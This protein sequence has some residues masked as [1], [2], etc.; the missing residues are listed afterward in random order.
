MSET[1]QDRVR[2]VVWWAGVLLV[3]AAAFA[4]D[5]AAPAQQKAEEK[6]VEEK[7]A[8]PKPAEKEREAKLAA[9]QA[10]D[11]AAAVRAAAVAQQQNVWPD[12][13]FER[14]VF[15]NDSNAGGARRRC[16]TLLTLQLDEI[17]RTCQLA[18]SQKQ[19]LRLLGHGD[20]KRIFDAFEAAKHHFNLLANDMN[21]FQEIQPEIMP[22]QQAIQQGPFG[23]DSLLMKSLRHVLTPE[24]AAKYDAVAKERRAFRHRARVELAIGML[25]QSMSFREGQRRGLIELL[26]KETKPTRSAT[27]YYDYYLVLY[28]LGRMEDKVK[29]MFTAAEWRIMSRHLNQYR[30]IVP[31]LRANGMIAEDDDAADVQDAPPE[32]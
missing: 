4:I 3:A 2:T 16:E 5:V 8:A 21:H 17:D 26:I 27:G 31:N 22:V 10:K 7:K 20:I 28:N 12:D 15:Q 24:Q 32:R 11:R 18:E 1:R 13:Q 19:K 29:P 23:D 14:W 9:A 25:E 30:G 6:K